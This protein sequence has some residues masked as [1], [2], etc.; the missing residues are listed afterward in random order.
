MKVGD[1]VSWQ[2]QAALVLEVYQSGAGWGS[3]SIPM[4]CL[5]T[6]DKTIRIPVTNLRKL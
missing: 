3:G 5:L 4:A 1:L 6:R 2:R